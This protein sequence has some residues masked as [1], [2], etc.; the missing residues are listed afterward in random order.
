MGRMSVEG[1]RRR[2]RPRKKWRDCVKE[3]LREKN[4]L[5]N[6]VHDRLDWRRLTK[7]TNLREREKAKYKKKI[8]YY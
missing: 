6:E 3:D 8:K 1:R 4:L 5:G 7:N 2:G